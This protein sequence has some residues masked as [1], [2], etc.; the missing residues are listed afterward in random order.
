[1]KLYT[2]KFPISKG[3]TPVQ[4]DNTSLEEEVE[5]LFPEGKVFKVLCMNANDV[6]LTCEGKVIPVVPNMLQV[7]FEE[8][9]INV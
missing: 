2:N 4:H 7:G 5:I 6:L 9:E 8:T 3:F 1:M